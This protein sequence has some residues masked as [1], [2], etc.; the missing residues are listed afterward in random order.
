MIRDRIN[1]QGTDFELL[2]KGFEIIVFSEKGLQFKIVEWG[3]NKLET[4]TK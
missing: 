2:D 4:K 1:L 3:N